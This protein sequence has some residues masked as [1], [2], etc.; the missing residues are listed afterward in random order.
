MRRSKA[1][2]DPILW[3]LVIAA[4]IAFGIIWK[5]VMDS[6]GFEDG[7]EFRAAGILLLVLLT[8][9]VAAMGLRFVIKLATGY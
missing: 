1:L 7:I 8:L 3:V 2:D 5:H 4:F 9:I 6:F